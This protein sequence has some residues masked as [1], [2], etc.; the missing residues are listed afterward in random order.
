MFP[1]GNYNE[2]NQVSHGLFDTMEECKEERSLSVGVSYSITVDRDTGIE[3]YPTPITEDDIKDI[4][5]EIEPG[6]QWKAEH[7]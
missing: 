3:V 5:G 1:H 4:G 6:N 7:Y 2:D